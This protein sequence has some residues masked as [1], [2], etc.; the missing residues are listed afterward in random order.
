VGWRFSSLTQILA[1]LT[2]NILS[3]QLNALEKEKGV[4]SDGT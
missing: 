3:A 1:V 4:V 2:A